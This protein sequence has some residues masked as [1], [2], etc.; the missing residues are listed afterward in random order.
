VKAKNQIG[1]VLGEAEADESKVKVLKRRHPGTALG[2]PG[3]AVRMDGRRAARA[4][5][6]FVG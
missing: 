2:P 6:G 3:R 4:G 5:R 1:K